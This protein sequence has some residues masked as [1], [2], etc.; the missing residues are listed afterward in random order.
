[1][2]APLLISNLSLFPLCCE[3]QGGNCMQHVLPDP[4]LQGGN[5]LGGMFDTRGHFHFSLFPRLSFSP[6]VSNATGQMIHPTRVTRP[7]QPVK[8]M[9]RV[10]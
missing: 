5:N 3:L 6:K 8:F 4:S 9:T 7:V 1:M 10:Q 2:E